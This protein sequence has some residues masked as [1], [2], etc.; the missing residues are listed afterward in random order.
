MLKRLGFS[1]CLALAA[2]SP[3]ADGGAPPGPPDAGAE[4]ANA[5]EPAGARAAIL[6]WATAQ[7]GQNNVFDP[8][9]VFFGDFTGDGA[10]DALAWVLYGSGGNSAMLDVALFRNEGGRMV[11][12]RSAEAYGDT[13]RNV[14]ITNGRITLTST[15]P[16]PGDPRCCPTGSQDW[17]IDTR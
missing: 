16:R 1:L 8:V 7:Y 10:P 3:S 15:M 17:T 12:Y 6:A 13:P 4:T 2:C 9:D 11:Y 5:D 14:V